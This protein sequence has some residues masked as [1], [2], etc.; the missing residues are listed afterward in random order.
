MANSHRSYLVGYFD[1]L[2]FEDR[3]SKFGLNEIA[4]KYD[5][6]ID[7][8]NSRNAKMA[9]MFE[10]ADFHESAYW[11]AEAE[12][13]I[14]NRITGAYASDSILIWANSAYPEARG[15]T[16]SERIALAKDP[17]SGWQYHPIPC[18]NFVNSCNELVCHSLEV[19]LPLRG[20]VSMGLAIL[21]ENRRVFLGAPLIEAARLEHAQT[22]LGVGLCPSFLQQTIPKRFLVPFDG[23]LK[24]GC[25]AWYG[26]FILDWPRH[27]RNTRATDPRAAVRRLN[28][29]PKVAA[30]YENTLRFLDQ[31]DDLAG[32]YE[33]PEET[34]IR[35]VY[36]EYS[37]E[38]LQASVRPVRRVPG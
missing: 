15:M 26:G 27:W 35:K 17:A 22:I 4:R 12:V 6:L 5:E 34:S 13:C 21:D 36:A 7:I 18:D 20:A 33:S 11:S 37:H 3:F 9:E 28:Q 16:D 10:H 25:D 32:Q 24:D 38:E 8:V 29:D 30:Y 19:E 23:H 2:G 1:V 31:S 14:F